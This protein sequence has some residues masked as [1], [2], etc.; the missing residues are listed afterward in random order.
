MKH[1]CFKISLIFI[2]VSEVFGF[3]LAFFYDNKV[4]KELVR[5]Y[6][7][8]VVNANDV[9]PPYKKF[10]AYISICE[11]DSLKNIKKSWILGKNKNWNSY[12]MDIRNKDYQKF[13]LK[14]ID[15]L[16]K[17][18]FRGLFFDTLDSYQINL[19]K[20]E[21][22]SY[23]NALAFFI[24]EVYKKYHIK[25]ILNRGFEV[26]DKVYPYIYALV[27]ESLFWGYDG[28]NYVK[29]SKNDRKWLINKLNYIKSKNI[30]V[31]VVDYVKP[32]NRQ[33]AKLTA[34]KIKKLGF[35]PYVTD[36]NLET[37]GISDFT[38]F[39][40]KILV[41]YISKQT[42]KMLLDS[43]RMLQLPIEYLG[44]I[45]DLKTP[46]EAEKLKYT[47][48]KYSGIVVWS[49]LGLANEYDKFY[50]WLLK[51]VKNNNKILFMAN[52]GF[53]Q[54]NKYLS[55]L[56]IKVEDNKGSVFD[57]FNIIKKDKSIEYETTLP[58]TLSYK[59]LIPKNANPL[60][61]IKTSDNQIFSPVAITKW[62]GYAIDPYVD[63]SYLSDV[64]WIVNP[65]VL[66]KKALRL[67]N[68][69]KPDYTT[70]NGERIFFSHLDGDASLSRVEFDPAKL[71]CE[72]IRDAVLKK[73]PKVPFGISFIEGEIEPYGLYPNLSKRL[74]ND[75]RSIFA[76]KN[77]EPASHTFSH[78][79]F[80]R[81]DAKLQGHILPKNY[82][83]P[84]PGYKFSIYR[85]IVGSCKNL[86]K[87]SPP[88]KPDRI[89]FWSGDCDPPP[90]AVKLAYKHG[91]LNMNG[92]DTTI[93]Y[94]HNYLSNIAPAGVEK[95][96]YYQIYTGE[97]DEFI[98][99]D[100]FTKNFWGYK[101]VIQ[102]FK[103]TDRPRRFKPIDIYFH[104]Y[105]GSKKASLNSLIYVFNWVLKKNVIRFWVSDYIKKVLDFYNTLL[106]KEG[107]HWIIKTNKQLR[108][109]RIKNLGYPDLQKSKGIL[110]FFPY[111]NNYY[112][113]LDGSGY[114]VLY[115]TKKKPKKVYLYQ[116]NA[117]IIKAHKNYYKLKAALVNVKVKFKNFNG[118]KIISKYK[119]KI[120]K[121]WINFN[122]S[123]VGFRLECKK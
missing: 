29:V 44:Y 52:F 110:G 120:K 92:G 25:I 75:A 70:E 9:K 78:P 34:Q 74:L 17:K 28:S 31:V 99:T 48:D 81:K 14:K 66:L 82:N 109:L 90:E 38:V 5:A 42:S 43:H 45:A 10:A 22:K 85:E 46:K 51:R 84:I 7:L 72:E 88:N 55:K 68:I 113:S 26:F 112:L 101:K 115:F 93:M 69:P 121:G 41:V 96:G 24:E 97:Q 23:E 32:K 114:Y 61:T 87:L 95:E 57:N 117:R 105:I 77:I 53:P 86:S 107:N 8:V 80:W 108:T 94:A 56:D 27:C 104:F 2:F 98:Y 122:S 19:P 16:Y 65:F 89:L 30:P 20:K 15:A 47:I 102:T 4:P 71:S 59:F 76:L 64:K 3:H 91:I 111:D 67:K 100:G 33:K 35:I 62:G 49:E 83:L 116:S 1:L 73:F 50:K 79:F 40:R 12:I 123:S 37:V 106:I 36:G 11:Q 58:S 63:D 118:C 6:D 21:W 54:T 13:L 39:R 103:L 60:L 18:G 119:Y